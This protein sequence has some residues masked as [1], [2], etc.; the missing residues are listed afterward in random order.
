MLTG[1]GVGV[2]VGDG[3][4]VGVAVALGCGDGVLDGVSVSRIALDSGF[5]QLES[6]KICTMIRIV[7]LKIIIR[8]FMSFSLIGGSS[9]LSQCQ[10]IISI[11]SVS[12]LQYC[13]N[14]PFHSPRMV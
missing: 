10:W 4:K 1:T 12:S 13:S 11:A 6:K 14:S 2:N 8:L 7:T 3:V 9:L 5:P